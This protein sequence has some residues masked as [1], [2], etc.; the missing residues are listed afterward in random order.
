M[1]LQ[2]V[3]ERDPEAVLAQLEAS[4]FRLAV[5]PSS[6]RLRVWP[7]NRLTPELGQVIRQH[8]DQLKALVATRGQETN[9]PEVAWRVTA[10][11]NQLPPPPAP[12]LLL[13]AKRG[14]TPGPNDCA[15]CGAP[16]EAR[17]AIGV[18]RCQPCRQA[19]WLVLQDR[20]EVIA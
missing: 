3:L 8:R 1:V 19:A 6:G 5:V 13:A 14:I 9:D 16:L 17:P 12:I 7:A 10:M 18:G 2:A 20:A 4:G 11:R 15:S